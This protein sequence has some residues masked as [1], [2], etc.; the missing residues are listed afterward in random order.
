M[1]FTD[2]RQFITASAS[3]GPRFSCRDLEGSAKKKK[4]DTEVQNEMD[5]PYLTLYL[6]ILEARCKFTWKLHVK[7]ELAVFSLTG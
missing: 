6:F 2:R 7:T 5:V 4:K 1:R 3:T